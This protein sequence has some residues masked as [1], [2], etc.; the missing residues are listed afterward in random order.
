[1]LL[2]GEVLF[3]F[4]IVH[5]WCLLA[6][7]RLSLSTVTLTDQFLV[8]KL[9]QFNIYQRLIVLSAKK[10]FPSYTMPHWLATSFRPLLNKGSSCKTRMWTFRM[11]RPNRIRS[12]EMCMQCHQ[13]FVHLPGFIA[14]DRRR[15][16]GDW[17]APPSIP[18]EPRNAPKK[19]L[20]LKI[21]GWP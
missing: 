1:M 9:Q 3:L 18:A 15:A 12:I 7:S 19:A 16:T 21:R 11:Q 5:C 17:R 2:F 14:S 8:S 13:P 6:R 10:R 4:N 20:V